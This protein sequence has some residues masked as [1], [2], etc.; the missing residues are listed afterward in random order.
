MLN[1]RKVIAVL[2]GLF[3]AVF[4]AQGTG[5]FTAVPSFMNYDPTWAVIGV[6]MVIAAFILWPRS[7]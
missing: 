1:F 6:V 2:I 3:G 7:K 4:F 5:L